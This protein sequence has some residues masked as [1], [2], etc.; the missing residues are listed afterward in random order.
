MAAVN[1]AYPSR[2]VPS[3]MTGE[4]MLGSISATMTYADRSPRRRAA[5]TYSRSRSPTTAARIVRLTT[6]VNRAP[7]VTMMIAVPLPSER[8]DEDGGD[9]DRQGQQH[10]DEAHDDLVGEA[11]P[12]AGD[13]ADDAAP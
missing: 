13:E 6:G 1:T 5:M 10:V 11:A 3:T 4:R 9:D 7:I 2:T 12:E 8:Q